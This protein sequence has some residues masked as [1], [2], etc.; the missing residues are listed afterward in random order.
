MNVKMFFRQ[1]PL[2]TNDTPIKL[3]LWTEIFLTISIWTEAVQIVKEDDFSDFAIESL[4]DVTRMS[5]GDVDCRR[6][7]KG[8]LVS[9]HYERKLLEKNGKLSQ[10]LDSSHDRKEP[11]S[12]RVGGGQVMPGLEAGVTGMCPGDKRRVTVPASLS[13]AH[14]NLKEGQSYVI[15]V[16][17]VSADPAPNVFGLID[18]DLDRMLTKEEVHVYLT[19]AASKRGANPGVDGEP[20]IE[21]LVEEIFKAEDGDKD[22]WISHE[23]F[24]GPKHDEL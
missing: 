4:V 21:L 16:E 17:L 12:F 2:R 3:L 13:D 11:F 9:V 1:S 5:R 15:E 6:C 8:D 18:R 19:E 22:G 24:S 10:V 7:A 14:L 20:S 23:E